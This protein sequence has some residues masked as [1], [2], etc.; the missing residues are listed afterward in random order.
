[1]LPPASCAVCLFQSGM[2][3]G[4]LSQP[5]S[6]WWGWCEVSSSG[7]G[8]ARMEFLAWWMILRVLSSHV[9]RGWLRARADWRLDWI[10]GLWDRTL[11]ALT[12]NRLCHHFFTHLR[13]FPF[14]SARFDFFCG[15]KSCSLTAMAAFL[16]PFLH[17]KVAE[18]SKLFT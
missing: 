4:F 15:L 10:L 2:R 1:M 18:K 6:C 3:D 14:A 13:S 16:I 8:L 9:W 5:P 11:N 12:I 17:L 7:A